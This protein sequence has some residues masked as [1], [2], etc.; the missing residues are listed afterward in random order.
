[1]VP[2]TQPDKGNPEIDGSIKNRIV[3]TSG[4]RKVGVS[5]VEICDR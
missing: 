2:K 5:E 4:T 3:N 1:M